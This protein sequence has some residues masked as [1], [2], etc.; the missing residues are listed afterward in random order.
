M[1][2]A[3]IE[4]EGGHLEKNPLVSQLILTCL[5]VLQLWGGGDQEGAVQ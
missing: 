1:L 3:L 2:Y 4:W 5:C